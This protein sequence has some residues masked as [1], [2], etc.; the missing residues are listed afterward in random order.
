MARLPSPNLRKRPRLEIIPFI[1]IMFFLLATF[2]MASLAM[3]ANEGL[4]LNLP[5]TAEPAPLSEELRDRTLSV[6]AEGDVY[7][8]QELLSPDGLTRQL[9]QWHEEDPERA[10]IVQGD[11]DCAYGD[12]VRILDQARR[13]GLSGLVLRTR[14]TPQP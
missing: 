2:M 6:D 3:V 11:A 5:Q 4:D 12:V 9:R 1:D 10:V 14:T 13:I 8:R 7:H